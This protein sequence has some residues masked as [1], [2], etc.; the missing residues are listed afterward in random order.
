MFAVDF[1]DILLVKF[2]VCFVKFLPNMDVEF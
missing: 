1:V 2:F